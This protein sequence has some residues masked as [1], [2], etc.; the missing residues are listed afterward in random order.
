M[1]WIKVI[2]VNIFVTFAL[3]GIL[4]L[5]PSIGYLAYTALISGGVIT[6][7]SDKRS[8]L[9][10]YAN[11]DWADIHFKE[12]GKLT[13]SYYDHI[14]WRRDDTNGETINI[15]NGLRKSFKVD[16]VDK[17]KSEYWF[18]GGST[19]WGSGVTD[20][21]TYPSLFAKNTGYPVINFGESAYI[22]RQSLSYLNNYL[23]QQQQRDLS[24]KNIIFYDGVNDV[25]H[26]C[27]REISGLGSGRE[28]QIQNAVIS[29]T[30][31]KFS[32]S[33][34]FEQ[35]QEFFIYA[36]TKIFSSNINS[37]SYIQ[38]YS[39]AS[40]SVRAIEV[41]NSLVDTWEIASDLVKSRGGTFTAV[42]QP[43]AYY[44]NPKID[45]LNLTSPND[46]NVA[47][48]YEAGYPLIIEAAAKRNINFINLSNAYDDCSNCYIDYCH[49]GPQ[50]H[51][52]L[53]EQL[54]SSLNI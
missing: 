26:R 52:M 16:A 28:A 3:I 35:L 12:I 13:T 54:E 10:I 15:H 1:S 29:S 9:K 32:V 36:Y 33:K 39:C 49:V 34:T 37:S 22:S 48:Q 50:A 8:E 43:V 47:K 11:Y 31:N 27:R 21:F 4:L 19:T 41:A 18:F 2:F 45:Y 5:T 24:G 42:L 38:P 7:V 51:L 17:I 44:G 23:I 20:D 30:A 46:L 40:D 53:V 25:S 14:S 6:D